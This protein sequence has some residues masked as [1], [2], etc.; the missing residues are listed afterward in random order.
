MG[1][2]CQWW[3]ALG[4]VAGDIGAMVNFDVCVV[5]GKNNIIQKNKIKTYLKS[6][7]SY[8]CICMFAA[9]RFGCW[10]AMVGQDRTDVCR[11]PFTRG[12]RWHYG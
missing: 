8:F 12:G 3:W 9:I 6:I 4:F 7:N 11:V 1:V 2:Y 10:N 5:I